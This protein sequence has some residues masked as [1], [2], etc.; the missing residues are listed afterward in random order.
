MHF[1]GGKG[2]P[3]GAQGGGARAQDAAGGAPEVLVLSTA[4]PGA[5]GA[6]VDVAVS[7]ADVDGDG[8]APGAAATVAAALGAPP[9]GTLRRRA[10]D[11]A[12]PGAEGLWLYTPPQPET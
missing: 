2:A 7:A 10:A 4:L 6:P 8:A 12:A 9:G 1:F 3:G 11:A 5:S